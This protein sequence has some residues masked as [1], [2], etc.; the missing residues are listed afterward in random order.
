M[1]K[2]AISFRYGRLRR[3]TAATSL[4]GNHTLVRRLW[5]PVFPS[6]RAENPPGGESCA[7]ISPPSSRCGERGRASP[8]ARLR[9]SSSAARYSQIMTWTPAEIALEFR[10]SSKRV[11]EVIRSEFGGVLPE[12]ETRWHLDDVEASRVRAR[13]SG[14]PRFS[15][16]WVA[17]TPGD[18]MRRRLIH[19]TYRGQQQGGISTPKQIPDVL[20]FTDPKAGARYGYDRFEGLRE[21][22]SY[23]YTGEGQYGDQVFVRGNSAIRDSAKNGKTIRL[24]T[25]E[26]TIATY[27]GAFTT[28]DPAYRLETIPD[29]D[30]APRTGI[31]FNLVPLDADESLLPVFGGFS[32]EPAAVVETWSAPQFSDLVLTQEA[33]PSS[34]ER[35]VSRIEFELQADFGKWLTAEGEVPRRLRLPAGAAIIEPDLYIP[36]RSWIVE[37]KK[38]AGRAYVRMAIGQVLDYAHSAKRSGIDARGVVLLP[39]RP[40]PDLEALIESL[41]LVLCFRSEGSFEVVTP[42]G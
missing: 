13:L 24:F 15:D 42:K 2:V 26:G 7:V 5:A 36:G 1:G 37:A 18:S 17:L 39:G 4:P 16:R 30:G 10:I 20:I 25:T 6:N 27:V 8:P 41:G 9:L 40:E 12:G 31:I 28:G 19:E 29:L 3:S 34:S 35:V 11:R 23:S 21:D 14:E 22:G 33:G 38:S 32:R